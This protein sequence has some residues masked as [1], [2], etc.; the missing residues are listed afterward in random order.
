[1]RGATKEGGRAGARVSRVGRVD[2]MAKT[3][4]GWDWLKGP[5][6]WTRRMLAGDLAL[7]GVLAILGLGVEEVGN[8]SGQR[9][10]LGA[11]AA[12]VL[13]LLRRRL[14]GSTLV[15]ASGVVSFLPGA[16]FVLPLLGWSAGRRII[17]VGRALAAF[18]LA[19]VAAIGCGV[20]DQWAQ[21]Q[22]LLVIVFS[23]LMFLATTVMP[24]LASRYWS[25]RRTLLRALQE[26]NGQLLR[27]R[28]MVAGQARLRERQRIAQDMHDSLGHQLALISVHTGALEVDPQLTDRQREAVGVLRQASVAA[29]HE[30]REV[31]GILR[32]GVEAPA[33]AEEAQPAARGVAGIAGVVEAARGSGTD[34]RLTTSG[35]PRPLVAACDHAAYRIVQEALTNA[36]KHAPGASITVEL[37]YEDDS[38]VVEIANG[39][40]AGPAADEVVSGGQGL[41]GL[42]ERARLVGGMVHAGPAEG[43]GFRVA[44]VLPY[45]AE[46]AGVDVADDFGQ[47]A[48]AYARG[49][50]PGRGGEQ[51]MDWEAVDRELAVRVPSRSGGVAVGCGIAFAA[52]V[53]L[54]IVFGA[55]VVLLLDSASD[56]MI[57]RDEFDAVHVGESEQ[58][59]RDRL[60]TGENFMTAGAAR[61]GPPRPAGSECLAL[62]AENQPSAVGTDRIFRFCFKDG[63]LVEKQEYEV[64]Q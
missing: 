17:G 42:R 45:G 61:K 37:R 47:Q 4:A 10:M 16:F 8:A 59:V 27:E 1:M 41:T 35:Q 46:P 33:P 11:V 13:T 50:L 14:P 6:P 53:L 55:G 31:V 49:P 22:P 9:M 26:R 44:G 18:T 51:P 25:Q 54:V 34:V 20:V 30:L 7:G 23:T 48:H 57:D 52:V 3:R 12:V 58:S 29:M 60:P 15:I 43:G 40:S 64:K 62:L 19:F 2:V 28:A 36:Y 39:P 32:D 5:E 24:G 21:M 63:K 56:A 38:L